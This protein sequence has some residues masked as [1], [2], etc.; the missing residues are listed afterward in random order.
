MA[1]YLK[2]GSADCLV[3]SCGRRML[4]A[5]IYQELSS[6]VALGCRYAIAPFA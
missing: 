5:G 3:L 4:S 1:S 6:W 2:G